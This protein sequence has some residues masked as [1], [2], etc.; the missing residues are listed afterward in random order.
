M[1]KLFLSILLV[2]G[3][4]ALTNAQHFDVRAYGGLNVVQLTSD[5]GTTI[6]DGVLHQE[7][8]SGRAGYQFGAMVTFGSRFF[9]Q[10]GIQ[11]TS[12]LTELKN[13]SE[14]TEYTDETSV[15]LISVP[16]RVGFRLID[17]G[18]ENLINVR[19]YGGFEGHHVMS[20]SHDKKSGKVGD[21][22]EDD[23]TNLIVQGDFG[24]GLD[25]AFVFI[26][27]GYQLGLSSITSGSDTK[28]NAFYGNVGV[29]FGF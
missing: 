17:P 27:M 23:F 7:T 13:S 16:L 11:Y 14:S 3:M 6:I 29:K 15:N 24:L 12:I 20:V 5:A 8:I 25:I 2:A 1:K 9:V 22:D 28:A 4:A 10:P 21:L 18:T 26:D 19:L